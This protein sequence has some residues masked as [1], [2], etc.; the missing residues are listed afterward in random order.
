M[1]ILTTIWGWIKK[2]PWAL[3]VALAG[4]I[5]ATALLLSRTNNV[6]SLDDAIQVRAAV[7]EIARKEARAKTLEQQ[8]D[9][10]SVEVEALKREVV[11]SKKR[12]ME[13]HN[14]KSLDGKTDADIAR[15]FADA[16][17]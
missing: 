15:L 3:I 6:S 5:G 17:F 2:Y 4:I 11:A 1:I 14:A 8:A 10:D 12:V 16:G 13:I 9:A 7:R